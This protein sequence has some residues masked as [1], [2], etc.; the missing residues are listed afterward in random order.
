MLFRWP[1]Q[2]TRWLYVQQRF[3]DYLIFRYT[4]VIS[5]LLFIRN[6]LLPRYYA[7]LLLF[8]FYT[9]STT[10]S[11]VLTHVCTLKRRPPHTHCW[12][13]AYFRNPCFCTPISATVYNWFEKNIF[14]YSNNENEIEEE[15]HGSDPSRIYNIWHDFKRTGSD[16]LIEFQVS[17]LQL[18]CLNKKKEQSRDELSKFQSMGFISIKLAS[19]LCLLVLRFWNMA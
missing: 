1:S 6:A 11:T 15:E 10:S 18:Q 7:I 19:F 9:G 14:R 17:I 5:A 4:R 12:P 3:P 13:H 16:E 8:K 2:W